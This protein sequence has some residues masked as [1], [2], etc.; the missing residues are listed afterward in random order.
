MLTGYAP[1]MVETARE[2]LGY[3]ADDESHDDEVL[4]YF[5]RGEKLSKSKHVNPVNDSN[6]SVK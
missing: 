3:K 6:E 1:Y 2:T 5:H 4:A